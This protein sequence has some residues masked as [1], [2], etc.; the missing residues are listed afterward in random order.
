[1]IIVFDSNII[2]SDFRFRNIE[3]RAV[4]ANAFPLNLR[5]YA[6]KVVIDEVKEKYGNE[7]ASEYSRAK[8]ALKRLNSMVKNKLNDVE[9]DI[10]KQREEYNDFLDK[11]FASFHVITDYPNVAH[12]E[13]VRRA[14]RRVKAFRE[15]KKR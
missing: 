1:M 9:L 4:L 15:E 10:G 11:L 8:G 6:P 13:I 2:F 5:L 12:V 14:I 3:T 7:V